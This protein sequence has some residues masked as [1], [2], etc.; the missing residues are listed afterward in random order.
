MLLAF[1]LLAFG[2]TVLGAIASRTTDGVRGWVLGFLIG[3][4]Y[5]L[6]TWMIWPVLARST[7]RQIISRD[8]WAKTERE[9]LAG[10]EREVSVA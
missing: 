9:P 6:Y 1:Y 2:G 8:G 7:A 10:G 4:L 3:H 5:A